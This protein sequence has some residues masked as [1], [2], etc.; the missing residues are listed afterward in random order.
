VTADGTGAG[1]QS[2]VHATPS[3]GGSVAMQVATQA[4]VDESAAVQRVQIR[5]QLA[6]AEAQTSHVTDAKATT[7]LPRNPAGAMTGAGALQSAD[8]RPKRHAAALHSSLELAKD[9]TV[10]FL[11]AAQS[12]D[13]A[14]AQF[15]K[16]AAR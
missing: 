2:R 16:M 14:I 3:A 13:E 1:V 9:W 8:R 10:E 5:A 15:K 6:Q 7:D 4:A 11:A 12:E